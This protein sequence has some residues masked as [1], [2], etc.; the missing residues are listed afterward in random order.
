MC[1]CVCVWERERERLLTANI[2]QQVEKPK[3]NALF[4]IW[5]TWGKEMNFQPMFLSF[6]FSKKKK[7]KKK[8]KKESTHLGLVSSSKQLGI[9]PLRGFFQDKK[10]Q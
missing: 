5:E 7:K 6:W 10:G 9:S 2:I 8:K 4:C 3:I 1:V